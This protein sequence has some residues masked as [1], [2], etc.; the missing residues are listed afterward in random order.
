MYLT[1]LKLAALPDASPAEGPVGPTGGVGPAGE[2]TPTL[3]PDGETPAA[4][5]AAFDEDEDAAPAKP[6]PVAALPPEEEA[7]PEPPTAPE[8]EAPES[9]PAK[10]E[11]AAHKPAPPAPKAR[12]DD[13]PSYDFEAAMQRALAEPLPGKIKVGDQDVDVAGFVKDF[14]EALAAAAAIAQRIVKAALA[15]ILPVVGS[16][17]SMR[18]ERAHE[19]FLSAV[20]KTFPD[21]RETIA[22][23]EFATWLAAQP[24]YVQQ[25]AGVQ[26][27]EA[28]ADVLARYAAASAPKAPARPRESA[29]FERRRQALT[30]TLGA[31]P[32]A[33]RPAAP[34]P[35]DYAAAFNEPEDA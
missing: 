3:P 33:R 31:R 29:E 32:A 1:A 16:V 17:E 13:T 21:V 4:F 2:P 20:A 30:G 24:Q 14:P 5:S 34:D 12:A 18:A 11:P 10:P 26:D 8:H 23:P 35:N 15:P 27:A 22:T 7:A 19:T 6:A 25:M 28:A 9:A